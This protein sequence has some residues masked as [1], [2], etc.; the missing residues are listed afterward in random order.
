MLVAPAI[1][2]ISYP[3]NMTYQ[4]VKNY[5]NRRLKG[6]EAAIEAFIT[7]HYWQ[8]FFP[9]PTKEEAYQKVITNVRNSKNRLMKGITRILWVINVICKGDH[10]MKLSNIKSITFP[11]GFWSGLQ[12]LGIAPSEVLALA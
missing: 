2:G 1:S 10:Y 6:T 12:Q 11:F 7:S 8:Y 4:G 3:F 5:L 9:S